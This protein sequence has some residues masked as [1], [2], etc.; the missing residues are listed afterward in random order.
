MIVAYIGV[1]RTAFS[2]LASSIVSLV[3]PAL[4][5]PAVGVAACAEP[6]P[7]FAAIDACLEAGRSHAE[8]FARFDEAR[9]RFA[10]KY[11]REEPDAACSK[12]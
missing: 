3:L 11:G 7:I 6:D 5:V 9:E 4:A 8:A 12:Q 10:E 2:T 1:S